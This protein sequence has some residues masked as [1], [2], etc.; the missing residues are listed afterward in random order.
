MAIVMNHPNPE[1]AAAAIRN[2]LL[3]R[4]RPTST[5]VGLANGK[6][7]IDS[8]TWAESKRNSGELLRSVVGR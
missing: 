5:E 1:E 6:S 8:A 3:A 2:E 7:V 4:A